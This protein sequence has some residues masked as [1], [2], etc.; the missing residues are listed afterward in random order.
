[1]LLFKKI[2]DVIRKFECWCRRYRNHLEEYLG[3]VVV[4]GLMCGMLLFMLGLFLKNFILF[5][6]SFHLLVVCMPIFWLI[7]ILR[8]VRFGE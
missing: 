2:F 3:C 8:Y 5:K 1:M 7:K 6:M 4:L